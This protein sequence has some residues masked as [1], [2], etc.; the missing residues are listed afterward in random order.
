MI[1]FFPSYTANKVEQGGLPVFVYLGKYFPIADP[2]NVLFYKIGRTDD[3]YERNKSLNPLLEPHRTN[4]IKAWKVGEL[5]PKVEY[6]A[7]IH[8]VN[9]KVNGTEEYF[10]LPIVSEIDKYMSKYE[11]VEDLDVILNTDV[12]ND[13]ELNKLYNLIS[14]FDS[15]M[16]YIQRKYNK[17]IPL[18]RE[19]ENVYYLSCGKKV[20]IK[21]LAVYFDPKSGKS[22]NNQTQITDSNLLGDIEQ[23]KKYRNSGDDSS[24][25]KAIEELPEALIFVYNCV[26]NRWVAFTSK[27]LLNLVPY[28]KWDDEMSGKKSCLKHTHKCH[29]SMHQDYIQMGP[30]SKLNNN[31]NYKISF[32]PILKREFNFLNEKRIDLSEHII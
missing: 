28:S 8:F 31:F 4:I 5:S 29:I 16:A 2:K 24:R 25:I 23:I 11:H 32:P 3:L 21:K 17:D 13:Q 18:K 12:S 7:K 30:I 1:G 19:S 22:P 10:N 20:I 26:D 15:F 6:D 14:D 27:E 9:H